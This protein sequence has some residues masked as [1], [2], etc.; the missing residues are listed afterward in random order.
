MMHGPTNITSQNTFL[1]GAFLK[2][3]N[4]GYSFV[5]SVS[6]SVRTSDRMK[7]LDSNR[8]DF[9]KIWYSSISW[10]ICREKSSAVKIWQEW[11]KIYVKNYRGAD[12]SLAW[13]GR[14][15]ARKH[16]KD[17]RDFNNIETHA[18]I[19]IFFPLARQGAE[20]NSRHS[21]RNI[22]LFPSWWG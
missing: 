1:L 10:K 2:I 18:I 3:A 6:P 7:Q 11:R 12:K 9:H 5:M 8:M 13:P 16:V 20:G 4:S 17:T 15:Q 14:K 19:K 21:D 22:D